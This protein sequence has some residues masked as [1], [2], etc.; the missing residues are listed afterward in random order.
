MIL[1]DSNTLHPKLLKAA[2]LCQE[3]H[4]KMRYFIFSI[5]TWL[6]A[7]MAPSA[8]AWHFDVGGGWFGCYDSLDVNKEMQC[9]FKRFSPLSLRCE[10]KGPVAISASQM[11]DASTNRILS[12]SEG[13]LGGSCTRVDGN[14]LFRYFKVETSPKYGSSFKVRFQIASLPGN[15]VVQTV[16]VKYTN[17]RR[18]GREEFDCRASK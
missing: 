7:T 1:F 17:G 3:R 5:L 8:A 16:C 13:Q 4:C 11:L 15:N 6:L 12:T 9:D 14:S 18:D 2:P 10:T